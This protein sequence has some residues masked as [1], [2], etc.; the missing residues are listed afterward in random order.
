MVLG[1][2]M[3]VERLPNWSEED[4]EELVEEVELELLLLPLLRL[5]LRE[6]EPGRGVA[7]RKERKKG[8][9]SPSKGC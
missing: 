8:V 6:E 9:N 5:T 7:G 4:E 3:A 1:E 2:G